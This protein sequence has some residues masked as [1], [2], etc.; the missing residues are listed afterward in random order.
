MKQILRQFTAYL[1]SF[2]FLLPTLVLA[3]EIRL[4]N[5]MLLRGESKLLRGIDN[6]AARPLQAD[7]PVDL[8]QNDAGGWSYNPIVEINDD[9]RKY[10][11]S[12]DMVAADGIKVQKEL[13]SAYDIF[14]IPQPKSAIKSI[15]LSS[16]RGVGKV[17]GFDER[18]QREMIIHTTQGEVPVIQG[19]T[20]LH[21]RYVKVE[22]LNYDW[23]VTLST[24]SIPPDVLKALLISA[25]DIKD[26]KVQRSIARFYLDAD[27]VYEAYAFLDELDQQNPAGA[28][29]YEEVRK[30]V[31]EQLAQKI[32]KEIQ[33]RR[34]L[35]QFELA[36]QAAQVMPR[37]DIPAELLFEIDQFLKQ[38][39]T[40]HERMDSLPLTLADL[41]SK[42]S[43]REQDAAL[44][45]IRR[46]VSEEL[47]LASLAR[48]NSFFELQADASL[49]PEQKL[50]LAYSGWLL[51]SDAA[52]DDLQVTLNLW[53][54][55]YLIYDYLRAPEHDT[56]L[57]RQ[58]DAL[59]SI[60]APRLTRL[61]E[62]LPPVPGSSAITG[63]TQ[64][65]LRL[66]DAQGQAMSY[67]V[68]TPLEYSP[69][70]KYPVLIALPPTGGD[71]QLF[72]EWWSGNQQ[73]AG[74]TLRRGYLLVVPQY[75]LT[76]G[77]A[78][79]HNLIELNR[80]H[81]TLM[82]V[83]RQFSVDSDRVFV[84]GIADGGDAAIDSGILHP[85]LYAG[86]IGI[87]GKHAPDAIHYW[88]NGKRLPWYLVGGEYDGR[89]PAILQKM[90]LGNSNLIYAQYPNRASEWYREE[91][92]QLFD[93][94]E[95]QKRNLDQL[96]VS[97]EAFAPQDEIKVDWIECRGLEARLT[98][99]S[100]RLRTIPLEAKLTSLKGD[101]TTLQVTKSLGTG[102][103]FYI[104]PRL[105]DFDQEL[106][107]KVKGSTKLR[108]FIKPDVEVIL[109]DYRT[110][111]DREQIYWA[112]FEF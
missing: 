64:Y 20:F 74:E 42:L 110:R 25:G 65:D 103:T 50:A 7:D 100:S 89:Q 99:L 87:R 17:T 72:L 90:F 55:R 8:N 86:V 10:F 84:A 63:A 82:E 6:Q 33:N 95:L 108:E 28:K 38:Y 40:D 3:D 85:D 16:F 79:N 12:D 57:V 75:H 59:E 2:G 80:I 18:G 51:G 4:E 5:G 105:H 34:R 56:E 66:I 13:L 23:N 104:S 112:K 19:I 81:D 76:Q 106:V 52:I 29:E 91:L 14:K 67:S 24:K 11:I 93:W 44:N 43:T 27:R 61:L 48:L 69:F 35:G 101:N 39:A 92:E 98:K 58:I 36:Y 32:F 71:P 70:R 73:N 88:Q 62:N 60:D 1:L 45:L 41:Q 68:L 26:P 109:H 31:R 46:I 15:R 21:P 94:M 9:I 22:G 102:H 53:E 97:Y 96:E 111:Y 37:E 78:Y 107:L 30:S 54:A 77:L 47:S 49:L 83:R